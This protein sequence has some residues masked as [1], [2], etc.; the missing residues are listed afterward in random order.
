M[1]PRRKRTYTSERRS[2]QAEVTRAE[3]IAAARRL[4]VERGWG[5][6]TI[7]AIAAE[8]GVSA[9]TIY[10]GFGNKAT[11][12]VAVIRAT[13]R[14]DAPDTPLVEQAGPRA[15]QAAPDQA[16]ILQLFSRDIA[17]L[18]GRVAPLM[19]AA[20]GAAETEPEIATV[21]RGIHDGRRDNLALVARALVR[22]GPLRG[23]MSEKAATDIIWRL[24]SPELYVVTTRYQGLDEA[25]YARWLEE[26]LGALLLPGIG[27]S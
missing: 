26:T 7:A 22:A 19:A 20:L 3:V 2:A 15:V 14:G 18:L 5:A 4:F 17:K 10:K 13:V 16:T 1:A 8:A 9:E 25:R 27:Q 11:L 23:N 21:Y 24:T 12:F 6:V